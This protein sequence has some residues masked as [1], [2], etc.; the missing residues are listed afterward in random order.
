MAIK[1]EIV[2]FLQITTKFDKTMM[3]NLVIMNGDN[4]VGWRGSSIK[5]KSA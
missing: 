4:M 1:V 3:S 5:A 2:Y